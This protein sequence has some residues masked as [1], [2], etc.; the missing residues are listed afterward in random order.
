LTYL[1]LGTREL[2]VTRQVPFVRCAAELAVD[3]AQFE[4]QEA[5][6]QLQLRDRLQ[7][8]L[9]RIDRELRSAAHE[10]D[11]ARQDELAGAKQEV[12]QEIDTVMGQTA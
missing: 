10:G 3:P 8:E 9:R 4:L 7:L 1:L 5:R 11:L 2:S 6:P 12:R